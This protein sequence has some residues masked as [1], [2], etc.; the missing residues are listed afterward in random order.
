MLEA[1]F[2]Y[3]KLERYTYLAYLSTLDIITKSGTFA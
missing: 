3:I 1:D 2:N